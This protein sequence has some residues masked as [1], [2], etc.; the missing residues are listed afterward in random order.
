MHSGTAALT[1][2]LVDDSVPIRQRVGALL[3]A[4]DLCV[5]G[6]AGT[7]R[8]A[9]EGI[10][11]AQ[12]AVV[13]LDVHLEGGTGLQVLRSVRRSAPEV[14]FVVF[15]NNANPIYRKR[16]LAEGARAFLDKATEFDQLAG[17]VQ[18]AAVQAAH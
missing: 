12:P 7:P 11:A 3:A 10:L 15:S 9:I 2:F 4:A 14:A 16:F 8:G 17:A 13:V 1:V 6:E 18:C 5:V